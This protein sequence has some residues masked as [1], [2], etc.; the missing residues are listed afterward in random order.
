MSTYAIAIGDSFLLTQGNARPHTVHLMESCVET[1]TQ[2]MEWP[3]CSP[4]LNQIGHVWYTLKRRVVSKTRA[5]T[6]SQD[7]DIVPQIPHHCSIDL[8]RSVALPSIRQCISPYCSNN[9][10][11][12]MF[13]QRAYSQY[14][15]PIHNI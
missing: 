2:C 7:L 4:D 12:L 13:L 5:T 3:K 9:L 10:T 1:E 6:T 8:F 15:S 14:L 11:F